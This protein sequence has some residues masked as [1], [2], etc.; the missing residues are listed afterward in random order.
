MPYVATPRE[1]FD[2]SDRGPF[3]VWRVSWSADPDELGESLEALLAAARDRADRDERARAAGVIE[4]LLRAGEQVLGQIEAIEAI[5]AAKARLEADLLAAYGALHS[6]EAQQVAAL[7]RGGSAARM[8]GLVSAERVV[9]E[10]I[11]LATGVGAGEV[12]RRLA[13][14]TAPRRHRVM[15]AALGEGAT[16]LHRVLQVAADTNLLCD[17]DVATVHEAVLAPSRDG[18]VVGQR[19]FTARL[20]RAVASVDQRGSQERRARARARRGVFGRMTADGMGYLTLTADG[21]S[22]A[23]VLDRLDTTAR[24]LRGNGDPRTLDQLRC[25]LATHALLGGSGVPAGRAEAAARVWLVVPFEVATGASDA[26]CEVPGHGWVTA[27]HAR[28][29]MTRPGSVWATLPVDLATGHAITRPSKSYRP[30]RAMVEHVQAIDGTCRGPDCQVPAA[31]CDLDHEAPW[32]AGPTAVV[33]L[34]TKHRLHHNVKTDGIWTSR[35]TGEGADRVLE[36]TTLTGRTYTT[37]PRNWR[38]GLDPPKPHPDS[39][40]PPF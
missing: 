35:P 23:A 2:A 15:L 32:P 16:S 18:R 13:V 5:E 31:R 12:A 36:W 27:A 28:E 19:T 39:H 9:T 33:N 11:S 38:D 8:A 6:I 34:F 37:H 40:P 21:P 29:V 25:D 22:I 14:A 24:S 3:R 30:S 1:P 7:P 4:G 20:R 26:A 17:A 10:E